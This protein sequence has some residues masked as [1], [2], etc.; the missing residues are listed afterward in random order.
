MTILLF[1][2]ISV[3]LMIRRKELY[4]CTSDEQASEQG[5][6]PNGNASYVPETSGLGEVEVKVIVMMNV[7]MNVIAK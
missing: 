5:K 6:E 3:P 4:S 1:S 7:N 2:E